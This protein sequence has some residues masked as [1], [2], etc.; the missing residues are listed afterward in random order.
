MKN[1]REHETDLVKYIYDSIKDIKDIK[2]Y[3]PENI[4]DRGD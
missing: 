4:K 3:G 2:I 1:I